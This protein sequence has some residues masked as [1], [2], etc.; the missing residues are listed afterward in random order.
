MRRNGGRTA[1]AQYRPLRAGE[2]WGGERASKS[3]HDV[4]MSPT[5]SAPLTWRIC[6][7]DQL[8]LRELQNIFTARQ[9]V[10]SVEQDCA[11]LDA[12]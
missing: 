4:R 8:T 3:R 10:F 5:S 11:Y 9:L 12:D 7:F 1:A 2:P 6:P